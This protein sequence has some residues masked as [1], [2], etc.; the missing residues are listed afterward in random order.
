MPYIKTVDRLLF[1][2]QIHQ[3][4]NQLGEQ[5]NFEGNLN[6]IISSIIDG[7]CVKHKGYAHINKIIG[8][9]EC[10]KL[11]YYRRAAAKYEDQ[12]IQENGDV[13]VNV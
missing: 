8:V 9:L 13:Y 4:V 10:A 3:L 1:D 5:P 11:E 2:Q 7:L 6:Y 12:K